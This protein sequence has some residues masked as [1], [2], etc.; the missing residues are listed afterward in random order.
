MCV[1]ECCLHS[2]VFFCVGGGGTIFLRRINIY[3]LASHGH[4]L[5]YIYYI[6]AYCT[7]CKADITSSAIF[8][9]IALPANE[10]TPRHMTLNTDIPARVC[11][12]TR[13][14]PWWGLVYRSGAGVPVLAV[15]CEPL[16]SPR[17]SGVQ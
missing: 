9:T 4:S 13:G 7:V 8:V 2:Y 1:Y 10:I 3:P 6:Q 15:E 16:C 17:A 14:Q 5:A 12:D 11:E